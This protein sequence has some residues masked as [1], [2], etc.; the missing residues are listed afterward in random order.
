MLG[1]KIEFRSKLGHITKIGLCVRVLESICNITH[2]NYWYVM[3]YY[4]FAL[5][6]EYRYQ[7]ILKSILSPFLPPP[8]LSLP[9]PCLSPLYPIF[10]FHSL[11]IPFPTLLS[12]FF[13]PSL[14]SSFSSLPCFPPFSCSPPFPFSLFFYFSYL[15]LLST[16]SSP[17][18][19]FLSSSPAV[20]LL[21]I[22]SPYPLSL[23][24]QAKSN[25]AN[26]F[27]QTKFN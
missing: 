20:F 19:P 12:F 6:F 23:L 25:Q 22:P 4:F 17:F 15:S 1:N 14:S 26:Q 3:K 9:Y 16:F 13:S 11:L 2:R 18:F 7:K 24:L 8:S 27:Q 5:C 10:P 21:P